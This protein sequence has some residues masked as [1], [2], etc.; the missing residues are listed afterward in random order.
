MATTKN[1][2]IDYN[3]FCVT[4]LALIFYFVFEDIFYLFCLYYNIGAKV[5]ITPTRRPPTTRKPGPTTKPSKPSICDLKFDS[6]FLNGMYHHNL[7]RNYGY[8]RE[9]PFNLKKRGVYGF[10]LKKYSDSQCC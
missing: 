6:I 4:Y 7:V 8:I 2:I 1:R 5:A 3:T 9:R 10:F